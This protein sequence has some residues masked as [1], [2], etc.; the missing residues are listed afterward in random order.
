MCDIREDEASR[1]A[2]WRDRMEAA[3]RFMEAITD[4]PVRECREPLLP[5]RDAVARA[6]VEVAFSTTRCAGSFDRLFYL[7]EGLL[8]PFLSAAREMNGRGW[9]LKVEDGYRTC[10]MQRALGMT[11]ETFDAVLARTMWELGGK[12]PTPEIM[13]RRLTAV[14]ATTPKIGTHMS[15][16]ALDISVIDR[17]AQEPVGRGAPYLE[18]SEL[19]PMDSPF[20]PADA[21]RNRE[22]ITALMSRHGFAAYPYEFWHYSSGDAYEAYLTGAAGPARYGPVEVD[23]ETG[24]VM[25]VEDP[26]AL[27]TDVEEI[28]ARIAKA[29]GKW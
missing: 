25:P 17:A 10:S 7:R 16:S 3:A 19:T 24:D 18:M 20:V 29:L 23:P 6:G 14:I 21:R 13:L 27:L 1:R 26:A 11:E 22:E 5:L 8:P 2:Y 28:D 12:T 9:V 15:G 4:F